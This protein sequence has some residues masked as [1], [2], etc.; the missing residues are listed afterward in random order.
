VDE[1][2]AQQPADGSDLLGL[3][4]EH[5]ALEQVNL[6]V[7]CLLGLLLFLHAFDQTEVGGL[8][9]ALLLGFL[10]VNAVGRVVVGFLGQDFIYLRVDLVVRATS[11]ISLFF[12][13]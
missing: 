11:R 13:L 3:G 2:P 1:E 12:R 9:P 5:D 4:H 6:H 7:D 8:L 10:Q